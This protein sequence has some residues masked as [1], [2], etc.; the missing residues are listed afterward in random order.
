M[1]Q[2]QSMAIATA[3]N[4]VYIGSHEVVPSTK[5]SLVKGHSVKSVSIPCCLK[6]MLDLLYAAPEWQARKLMTEQIAFGGLS[7]RGVCSKC[8]AS[9]NI[10]YTFLH[11]Q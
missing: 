2:I 11:H 3:T 9:K 7:T 5:T 1:G 6:V 8:R 4:E 10:I